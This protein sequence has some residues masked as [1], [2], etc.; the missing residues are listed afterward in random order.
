MD[1]GCSAPVKRHVTLPADCC[2]AD[3]GLAS[4]G[5][6]VVP[7]CPF[8]VRWCRVCFCSPESEPPVLLRFLFPVAGAVPVSPKAKPGCQNQLLAHPL[9]RPIPIVEVGQN[10]LSKW[11]K[12][13]CQNHPQSTIAL[14]AESVT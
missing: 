1:G 6:R 13:G 10:R 5:G 4:G 12:P 2:D 3:C 7:T 8:L 14:Y 9:D 11:A